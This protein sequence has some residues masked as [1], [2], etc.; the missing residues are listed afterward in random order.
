[1]SCI[2]TL[3]REMGPVKSHSYKKENSELRDADM[4][5]N[6]PGPESADSHCQW[7]EESCQ[8]PYVWQVE[9]PKLRATGAAI[10]HV[11]ASD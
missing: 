5:G 2:R 9:E 8:S 7:R 3:K 1:M 6:G 11:S 10:I 4:L